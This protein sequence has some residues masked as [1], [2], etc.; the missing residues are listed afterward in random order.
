MLTALWLSPYP[1]VVGHPCS[2]VPGTVASETCSHGRDHAGHRRAAKCLAC[3]SCTIFIRP[4]CIDSGASEWHRGG[5]K[6]ESK[7][8]QETAVVVVPVAKGVPSWRFAGMSAGLGKMDAQRGK[9]SW[10][11]PQYSTGTSRR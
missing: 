9:K 10:Q 3:H 6:D 7:L 5:G 11:S 2:P 4:R 1:E 8:T